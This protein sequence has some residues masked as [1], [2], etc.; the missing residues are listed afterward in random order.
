[1]VTACP[2]RYLLLDNVTAMGFESK[3]GLDT[4]SCHL[5]APDKQV[6]SNFAACW[7]TCLNYIMKDIFGTSDCNSEWS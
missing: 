6:L 5:V 1:M 3:R 2:D 7:E 4:P